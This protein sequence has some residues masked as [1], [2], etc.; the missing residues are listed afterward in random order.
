MYVEAHDAREDKCRMLRDMLPTLR[1]ALVMLDTV[2]NPRAVD[3]KNK[4]QKILN[5]YGNEKY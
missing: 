3:V 1:S 2:D 4:I 5:K